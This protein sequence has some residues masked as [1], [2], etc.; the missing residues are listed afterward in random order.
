MKLREDT[1]K[2][3]KEERRPWVMTSNLFPT[4]EE[5]YKTLNTSL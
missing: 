2:G 4:H 1:N 5:I 3:T